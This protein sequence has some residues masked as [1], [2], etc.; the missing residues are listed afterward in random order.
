ALSQYMLERF[1]TLGIPA[2]LIRPTDETLSPTERVERVLSAYGNNPNVVVISNHINSASN[3]EAEGAEVIYALR[4]DSTLARNILDELG[5]AGQVTRSYYQ[6]RLPSDP[7]KDYYFILRNTGNT[8]PVLIEY[9]FITNPIDISRVQTNYKRYAD[10]VVNAV[11][12]TFLGGTSGNTY[13]VKAGDTLWS[14]ANR[15]NTSVNELKN[16]NNLTSD[17]LSIGQK[18]EI[19]TGMVVPGAGN[20][21]VVKAGD[22]LWSIARRYNTTVDDIKRLNNL[23]SNILQIGQTLQIPSGEVSEGNLYTV[24]AGDT[25]W[26]IAGQF[27]VSVDELK[28]LNNLNNNLI[29]IGQ[30]LRIP[31][32][33]NSGTGT[34]YIVKAGDTLWNIAKRYNT[35]VSNI[36]NINNLTSDILS[37]GQILYI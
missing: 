4:N 18:L 8:Q 30:I 9:G 7:T 16:L 31:N 25:L 11:V 23:T 22:N 29:S 21:Y 10:A 2:T 35:T 20:R 36:R 12:K 34:R 14:I 37:I 27:K 5:N 32:I 17:I 33:S 15:F 13:T 19:P 26:S 6:R 28:S 3:T 24:K 1:K